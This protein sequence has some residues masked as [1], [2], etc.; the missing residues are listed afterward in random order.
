[1]NI[2]SRRRSAQGRKKKSNSL[3]GFFYRYWLSIVLI[4]VLSSLIRQNFIVN[5]FPVDIAQKQNILRQ[6][7]TENQDLTQKNQQLKLELNSK[8]DQKL[9]ILES[10]ARYKFGLIK[11]GEKYYQINNPD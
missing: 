5:N 4:L 3:F 10:M 8:S 9:E 2:K 7:S 1:M 6:N 11:S